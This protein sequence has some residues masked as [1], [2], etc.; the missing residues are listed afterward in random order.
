MSELNQPTDPALEQ[1]RASFR[2]FYSIASPED[3]D[4]MDALYLSWI[5]FLQNMSLPRPSLPASNAR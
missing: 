5:A 4:W 1:A 3:T 2:A